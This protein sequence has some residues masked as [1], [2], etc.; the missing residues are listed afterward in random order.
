ML[1]NR[2]E[3]TVGRTDTLIATSGAWHRASNMLGPAHE[4]LSSYMFTYPCPEPS[5]VQFCKGNRNG[6][7]TL[8][9]CLSQ[10]GLPSQNAT[11]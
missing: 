4:G 2:E 5:G 9:W 10:L 1:K 7:T 11:G 8:G 6:S 3:K